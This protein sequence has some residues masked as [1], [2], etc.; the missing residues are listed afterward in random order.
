MGNVAGA[1]IAGALIGAGLDI[2]HGLAIASL[3]LI[4]IAALAAP[5]LWLPEAH[6]REATGTSVFQLPNRTMLGIGAM[7]VLAFVVE[8]GVLDW[9][10]LFLVQAV[11]A[12]P[13]NAAYGLAAFSLAMTVGRFSGDRIVQW[14]GDVPT[15]RL[16][17]LCAGVGVVL[18]ALAPTLL[19][20]L[21]GFAIA[22]LGISNLVPVL[23]SVSGR[24]PGIL[25][26][27]GI[28]MAVTMAYGG[29]LFG[30]P[31]IGFV[32]HAHGMRAAFLLIAAA[33]LII[34]AMVG[35]IIPHAARRQRRAAGT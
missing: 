4:V 11:S 29:G 14:L 25:P 35:A 26:A 34:A 21:P 30:P 1:L 27:A 16:S 18:V 13:A 10:A 6:V 19:L 33:V 17:A 24:V 31:L 15:V 9:G 32:A 8:L 5:W 20:A 7:T 12:S 3:V 2:V 28:A 22:G 23:F